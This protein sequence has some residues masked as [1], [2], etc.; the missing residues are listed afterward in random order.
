MFFNIN[1][2]P[3]II[4]GMFNKI[5]PNDLFLKTRKENI[6]KS[7]DSIMNT[8]HRAQYQELIDALPKKDVKKKNEVKEVKPRKDYKRLYTKA[9]TFVKDLADPKTRDAAIASLLDLFK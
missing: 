7:F 9:G 4:V 5:L 1:D 3:S 8:V 6:L 2:I